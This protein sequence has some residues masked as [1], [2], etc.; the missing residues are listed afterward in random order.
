[1]SWLIYIISVIALVTLLIIVVKIAKFH[2]GLDTCEN[3]SIL[4]QSYCRDNGGYL[5]STETEAEH[6]F[7]E[8]ESNISYFISEIHSAKDQSK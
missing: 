1:M 2:N 5:L 8:G 3:V 6:T 7:I 4:P